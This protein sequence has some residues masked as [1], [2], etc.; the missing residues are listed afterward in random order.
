MQLWTSLL[1]AAYGFGLLVGSRKTP[2][3]PLSR[4]VDTDNWEAIFGWLSDRC[5]SRRVPL[6]VGLV[7]LGA[8]TALL[9]VATNIYFAL[10]SRFLQ[11]LSASVV[12]AIGLALLTDT[13]DR[14]DIGQFI[15]YFESSANMGVLVSPLLGGVVYAKAGYYAVFAMLFALV[16][17]DIVLRLILVER[18]HAGKWSLPSQSMTSEHL[19]AKSATSLQQ[20][21]HLRDTQTEYQSST[22]QQATSS[23]IDKS[24]S[25]STPDEKQSSRV[26]YTSKT[27]PLIT[28]L[29]TPRLLAALY[30]IFIEYAIVASFNAVLPPFVQNTF[31]WNSLGAGLISL[32]IALPALL[33]PL[34]GALSDRYGP[35]WFSICGLILPAPPM[36][37]LRLVT[38]KGMGQVVLLCVLLTLIGMFTRHYR[39]SPECPNVRSVLTSFVSIGIPLSFLLSPLGAELTYVVETLEREKPGIFGKIGPY[40][41]T[42]ALYTCALAL[43]S[44]LAPF[45]AGI[46]AMRTG[47]GTMSLVL[48]VFNASGSGPG[49]LKC[50]VRMV[51]PGM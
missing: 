30:G 25:T 49:V 34:V 13:V 43:A 2:N 48:G 16:G 32:C 18:K 9:C 46:L 8:G 24:S 45:C 33:S 28:L 10:A 12:F 44:M 3:C 4:N 7:M 1:F 26:K 11:G 5:S 40:G 20:D 31:G 23:G 42:F 35:R 38:H 41:Q 17:L 14:K 39:F 21:S 37:L 29:K 51:K 15:G 6:L 19:N 27:P 22:I 47:W 36:I 50:K